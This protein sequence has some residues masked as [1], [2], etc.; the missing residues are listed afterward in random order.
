ME[1]S[2]ITEVWRHIILVSGE[3]ERSLLVREGSQRRADALF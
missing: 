2:K 3:E 1:A